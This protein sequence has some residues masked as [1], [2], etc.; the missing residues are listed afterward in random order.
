MGPLNEIQLQV[1]LSTSVVTASTRVTAGRKD[2]SSES[3]IE[4]IEEDVQRDIEERDKLSQRIR[5]RE[6][7][8][9]RHVVSKSEAKAAA[10]AASR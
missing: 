4:K 10:D 7:A 6:K 3:D 8:N 9:T 2:P 5:Q 1:K